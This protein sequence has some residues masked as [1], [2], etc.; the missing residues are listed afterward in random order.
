[1]K[2]LG[3]IDWG[4][5][6]IG[7]YKLIKEKLGDVSVT[8]FSDTGT[9]PY[10]KMTSG[11]LADRLDVVITFLISRGI[12]HLAI[13]CNAASTAIPLISDHGI[14]IQGVIKPAI[15]ATAKL[16]PKRLGLI[17]GR[18]TVMSGVYRH[19]FAEHG[20]AIE[21]RIAQPLSGII[22]SGDV[23]S[24]TLFDECRRILAPLRSCSHILLACTHYPAI[25]PVLRSIV[26]PQ[27]RFV[28]PAA[29]LVNAISK[30]KLPPNSFDVFLTSGEVEPMKKAALAAFKVKIPFASKV[31]I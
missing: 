28:D 1:M 24:E 26:S 13:G 8:Y 2:R 10:G 17:G 9:T 20:I 29:A 19:G 6:G 15:S 18:R 3:I 22:E 14:P 23:S 25:E 12:T 21:Q 31:A 5:G 4:I 16:R 27:T 30:W 7:V 11:E